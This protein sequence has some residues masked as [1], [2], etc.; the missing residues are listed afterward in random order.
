MNSVRLADIF[1]QP[2]VKAWGEDAMTT[3]KVIEH[4][5]NCNLKY[6]SSI[7]VFIFYFKHVN[8]EPPGLNDKETTFLLFPVILCM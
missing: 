5:T 2:V 8:W 4:Q 7:N 1:S 6:F 3:T